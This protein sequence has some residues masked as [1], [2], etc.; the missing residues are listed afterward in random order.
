LLSAGANHEL[1]TKKGENV[2]DLCRDYD[3]L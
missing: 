1:L 3:T 2:F